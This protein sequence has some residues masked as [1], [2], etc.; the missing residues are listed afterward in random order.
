MKTFLFW[1]VK[2]YGLEPERD[3]LGCVKG[4]D[5]AEAIGIANMFAPHIKA[6]GYRRIDVQFCIIDFEGEG[7]ERRG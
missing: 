1:G 3:L 4:K 5:L 2:G 7:D 6:E